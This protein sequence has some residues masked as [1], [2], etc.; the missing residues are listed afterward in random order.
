MI[1]A[2]LLPL[3]AASIAEYLLVLVDATFSVGRFRRRGI[4]RGTFTLLNARV[5]SLEDL[6]QVECSLFGAV[7]GTGDA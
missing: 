7:T 6:H 1:P 2:M 3:N 5:T 4:E